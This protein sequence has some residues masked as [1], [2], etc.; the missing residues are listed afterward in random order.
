MRFLLHGNVLVARSFP[1]H[2]HH[3]CAV[4]WLHFNPQFS[5]CPITEGAL[6]RYIY[7]IKTTGSKITEEALEML[8]NQQAT[9]SGRMTYHLGRPTWQE[10]R[11]IGR[12]LTL[13]WWRW[14]VPTEAALRLSMRLSRSS[15]LKLC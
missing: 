7:R 2:I 3:D 13:T 5:V 11:G 14:Q 12:S 15:I 1:E 4:K 10:Y 9:S 8:R 6:V